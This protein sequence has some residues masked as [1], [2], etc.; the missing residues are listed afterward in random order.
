ME[1]I[2]TVAWIKVDWL[3]F[4]ALRMIEKLWVFRKATSVVCLPL[5]GASKLTIGGGKPKDVMNLSDLFSKEPMFPRRR[6]VT[7]SW[8]V[9]R[10]SRQIRLTLSFE[11][12]NTSLQNNL[13]FH[14]VPFWG[15]H[16]EWSFSVSSSPTFFGGGKRLHAHS[17]CEAIVR[18]FENT[19]KIPGTK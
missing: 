18:H 14:L 2:R 7:C 16:L 3:P 15:P 13:I 10:L 8:R 4:R 17:A 1:G 6:Q 11:S 12:W 19:F 9:H 5:F